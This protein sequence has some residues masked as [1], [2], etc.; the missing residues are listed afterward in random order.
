MTRDAKDKGSLAVLVG[1]VAAVI[2]AAVLGGLFTAEAVD[3]WYGQLDRPTWSP[4]DWVFSP[5]W[6]VLYALIA[7]SAWLVY[8]RGPSRLVRWAM[9]V[10]TAQLVVNA[11]W[12]PVFFGARALGAGAI[13]VGAL[14]VL[15]LLNIVVF[16]RVRALAGALL[17]PYAAWVAFAFALNLAIWRMN[18]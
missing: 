11:V 10:W 5:V 12:S 8:L 7:L 13:I 4:P 6:T 3:S 18:V 14:E 2:A 16:W 15:V 9:T 17:I 1:I